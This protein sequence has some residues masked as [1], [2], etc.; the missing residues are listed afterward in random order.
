MLNNGVPQIL[1]PLKFRAWGRDSHFVVKNH[2]LALQHDTIYKMVVEKKK[3]KKVRQ[4]MKDLQN[5]ALEV[6][7]CHCVENEKCTKSTE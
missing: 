1:P 4:P 5:A 6:T 2:F 7:V 3:T